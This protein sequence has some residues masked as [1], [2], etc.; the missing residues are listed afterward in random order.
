MLPFTIRQ[1]EIF[2]AVAKQ[3]SFTGA[4]HSLHLTQPAISRQI[5]N[6]EKQSGKRL[7][8]QIGKKIYLTEAG[9]ILL[10]HTQQIME[11]LA[12]LKTAVSKQSTEITG[13]LNLWVTNGLQHFI[14]DIIGLF[15]NKYP[16]IDLQISVGNSKVIFPS[17]NKNEIDFCIMSNNALNKINLS[18]ELIA[19]IPLC[20]LASSKNPLTKDKNFSLQS[21]SN[22]TFI[23]GEDATTCYDYTACVI[24]KL[25]VAPKIMQ[26]KNFETIRHAVRANIGIAFLP[27]SIAALELKEKLLL[28]IP[29]KGLPSYFYE[30]YWVQHVNKSLPYV[31][32]LFKEFLFEKLHNKP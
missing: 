20:L 3:L 18:C 15:Y 26:I 10:Q 12:L 16:K 1:L 23:V 22:E 13:T 28:T 2:Y 21:L 4:S 29:L 8:E 14:F 7:F 27:P 17:F 5:N 25:K 9:N 24:K 19:K 32:Q 31:A 6:L 30:I 11:A